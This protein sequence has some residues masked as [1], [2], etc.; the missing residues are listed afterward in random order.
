MARGQQGG[1]RRLRS[2]RWQVRYRTPDRRR[3]SA[4][5]TF[6]TKA[7]ATQWLSALQTSINSGL[8]WDP[9]AGKEKL[10]EYAWSWLEFRTGLAPRTLEI[11]ENQ[12]RN[13]ILPAAG[14]GCPALGE[15]ALRDLEPAL[16]R[17]W[18]KAL[19]SHCGPSVAAKAYVRLRQI[20]TQAVDDELIPKNPC[21]IARGGV[22]HHPEQHFVTLRELY[23]LADAV[24]GRYRALLLT[25]G[26]AGLREGELLALRRRDV[27][28][29]EGSIFV[30]QKRLRLSSGA[31]LENAPKTR[32][33][34]RR[35]A[36][37]DALVI[38]LKIHLESVPTSPDAYVFTSTAGTPLDANNFRHRV[39][40]PLTI[41]CGMEGLR[42]HDLRHTAGTLAA[43]TGATTKEI[44]ARLGHASPNAAMMYQHATADRDRVIAHQL[45]AMIADV[46]SA[47]PPKRHVRGPKR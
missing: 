16:I 18:Y 21:K 15:V 2:G 9:N 17:G 36:I 27:S 32:A 37:P 1:I 19:V 8:R 40:I 6:A 44:M 11:Y 4:P 10:K 42:F 34:R 23:T 22:E 24:E 5:H 12:L 33:G 39:W 47:V 29:V 20:L 30:R 3:L 43:R 14:R 7:A 13:H 45:D 41:A 46:I 31:I 26:L 25:A 35:V 28:L 38:E